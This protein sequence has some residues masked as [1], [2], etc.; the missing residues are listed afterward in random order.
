MQQLLA[1]NKAMQVRTDTLDYARRRKNLKIRGI[2]ETIDEQE[3]P[4][5]IRQLLSTLLPQHSTRGI[6]ID[7]SFRLTKSSSA[8]AGAAREVLTGD[9]SFN[10]SQGSYE[11]RTSPMNGVSLAP[12]RLPEKAALTSFFTQPS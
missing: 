11:W 8:P 12:S 2:V 5:L 6:Q 7:G 4:H 1:T 3:L 10:Q 9:K